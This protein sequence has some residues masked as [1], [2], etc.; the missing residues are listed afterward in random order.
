MREMDCSDVSNDITNGS[1]RFQASE[2]QTVVASPEPKDLFGVSICQGPN[3][4]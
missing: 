3:S 2:I 4:L 1:A